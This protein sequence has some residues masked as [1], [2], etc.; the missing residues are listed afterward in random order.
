MHPLFLTLLILLISLLIFRLYFRIKYPFWSRQPVFHTHNLF[1]WIKPPGIIS[2]NLPSYD[3]FINERDIVFYETKSCPKSMLQRGQ[4][5]IKNHYLRE[6]DCHFIPSMKNLLPY[7]EYHNISSFFSFYLKK[8]YQDAPDDIA[9]IMTTRPLFM[10]DNNTITPLYYVDYLCVHPNYRKSNIATSLIHNHHF[11]QRRGEPEVYLSL[12]KREGKL[13][14]LVPFCVYNTYFLKNRVLQKSIPKV[15]ISSLLV[16]NKL[17]LFDTIYSTICNSGMTIITSTD[18]NLTQLIKTKNV[19]LFSFVDKHQLIATF[20][21]RDQTCLYKNKR[22]ASIYA[23]FSSRRLSEQTLLTMLYLIS[24]Q[25][26]QMGFSYTCF[27]EIGWNTNWV[28]SLLAKYGR[29]VPAPSP[30]GYYWYN[31]GQRPKL[32]KDVMFL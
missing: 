32:A 19:Y 20:F 6:S 28:Q 16:I 17:E 10:F 2:Y 4:Q 12:F 24:C 23:S 21:I 5:F 9:G 8:G 13:M 7:F 26:T 18:S 25:L 15:R 3:S 29:K 1:W 30:T 22:T 11:H 31:F 14:N 27:E